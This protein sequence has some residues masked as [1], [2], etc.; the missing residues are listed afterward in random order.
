MKWFHKQPYTLRRLE[1][2]WVNRCRDREIP[3]QQH[4]L[5]DCFLRP[6]VQHAPEPIILLANK[7]L[8]QLKGVSAPR[9]IKRSRSAPCRTGMCPMPTN[10]R[11]AARLMQYVPPAG[12]TPVQQQD[13]RRG[14]TITQPSEDRRLQASMILDAASAMKAELTTFLQNK[15][16][17]SQK[18]PL[19]NEAQFAAQRLANEPENWEAAENSLRKRVLHRSFESVS[20]LD[21]PPHGP[22]LS[23]PASTMEGVQ[24]HGWPVT[25][26]LERFKAGNGSISNTS[27]LPYALCPIAEAWISANSNGEPLVVI[28]PVGYLRQY[29]VLHGHYYIFQAYNFTKTWGWHY[30]MDRTSGAFY[31]YNTATSTSSWTTQWELNMQSRQT[32]PWVSRAV[33]RKKILAA[34][35]K[36]PGASSSSGQAASSSALQLVGGTNVPQPPP[37]F[38]GLRVSL[39]DPFQ[40]GDFAIPVTSTTAVI[41]K[42][43]H[44]PK[45]IELCK[46]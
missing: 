23:V 43:G 10:P 24:G 7:L 15:L 25:T 18:S 5:E 44:A 12:D 31:Y 36:I 46:A 30:L 38:P 28:P 16:K 11:L 1:Q 34:K 20:L 9:S 37:E 42:P 19:W 33:H 27:H 40:R 3:E 32:W 6:E 8:L 45:E 2:T 41:E 14:P 26:T 29:S 39:R 35:R 13:G 22:N 17:E 4:H 21:S